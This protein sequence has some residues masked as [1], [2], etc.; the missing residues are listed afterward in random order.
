MRLILT[1]SVI[2][3]SPLPK[4][5]DSISPGFK[6][7]EKLNTSFSGVEDQILYILLRLTIKYG[8]MVSTMFMSMM[9]N[10]IH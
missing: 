10:Q 5:L 2:Y 9:K 6:K 7:L 1:T 8:C 3:G 4:R